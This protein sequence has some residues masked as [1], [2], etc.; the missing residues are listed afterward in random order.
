MSSLV[1]LFRACTSLKALRRR[2]RF[3]CCRV[4]KNNVYK[5]NCNI[6]LPFQVQQHGGDAVE[7]E[8]EAQRSARQRG[9]PYISPYDDLQERFNNGLWGSQRV[10]A[11]LQSGAWE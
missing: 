1:W 9:L 11:G 10:L 2:Q 7:A 4:E 8:R 3:V 5:E 6:L